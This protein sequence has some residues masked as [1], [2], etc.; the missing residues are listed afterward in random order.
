MNT[1]QSNKYIE[2][3]KNGNMDDIFDYGFKFGEEQ[4]KITIT[5]KLELI[6]ALGEGSAIE[7]IKHLIKSLK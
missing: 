1:E 7:G 5:R 6:L 3:V 2:I 4:S